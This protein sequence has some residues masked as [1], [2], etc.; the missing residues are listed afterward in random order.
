MPSGA[1]RLAS[2]S[3]KK[4]ATAL[5]GVCLLNT[6]CSLAVNGTRNVWHEITLHMEEC[7][8]RAK[9]QRLARQELGSQGRL[10][11]TSYSR[12]YASGFRGR[13]C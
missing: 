9:F 11:T 8:E 5:L 3:M 12:E 10:C 13:I 6:G 4:L 1:R 7:R 2:I